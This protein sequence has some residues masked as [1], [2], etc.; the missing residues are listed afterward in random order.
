[1][2]EEEGVRCVLFGGRVLIHGADFHRL[3][4]EPTRAAADL[5]ELALSLV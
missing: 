5:R 3:S 1:M 2:A 4:G